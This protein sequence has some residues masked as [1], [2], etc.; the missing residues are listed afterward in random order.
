LQQVRLSIVV[1]T[2]DAANG[3]HG[4]KACDASPPPPRP[5]PAPREKEEC[6]QCPLSRVAGEGRG[7]DDGAGTGAAGL[8]GRLAR[9]AAA[10]ELIVADGGST[11]ATPAIAAASGA[12]VI[13]APR[14][15]GTQLCAGAAV[16]T[17][18]WLLFL[19]ADSELGQAALAAARAHMADP[20]NP[21]RAGYFRFALDDASPPARRLER[22]VAWRCRVFALP[23]GDQGL[24][25]S[26]ALY[27]AVGGHAPLPL[28]E[29]VDLVWRLGRHRLAALDAPL[30]TSATKFRRDGYLARSAR[31]LVILSLWFLG[32]PP[33]ILAKLY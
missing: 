27:D 28:M 15:R 22:M 30:M 12:R 26:R 23:Y 17:G 11:D 25:I 4:G 32:V 2:L 3:R 6:R 29:D 10:G 5:S 21:M 8:A 20:A 16:T 9:L 33:R 19:H 31:N 24:L 1:P 7:K 13:T 18:D 14:G